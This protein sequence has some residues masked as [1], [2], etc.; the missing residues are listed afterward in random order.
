MS[1]GM[2][3]ETVQQLT[4]LHYAYAAALD[5]LDPA[6]L[7]GVFHADATLRVFEP[8]ADEPR[9]QASGHDQLVLMIDAMRA[10]YAKTMHVITNITASALEPGTAAGRAY[11][12]SHHLLRR[13]GPPA[14]FVMHLV[15]EDEFRCDPDD[16]W[17]IQQRDIRFQWAEESPVLPWPEA[18]GRGGLG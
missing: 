7:R 12:V 6:A 2:D 17:R 1:D 10:R 9:S 13:D 18:L 3:A 4:D 15:Y 14:K 11:C 16:S 5:R 8:D